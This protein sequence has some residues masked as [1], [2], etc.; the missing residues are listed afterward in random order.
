RL[1]LL[2]SGDRPGD[3]ARYRELRIDAHLLK[4]VQPEELIETIY[5]VMSLNGGEVSPAR[6]TVSPAMPAVAP[7]RI[8][9]AEDNEFNAQYLERLLSMWGHHV[10]LANDG[11]E[12]LTLA[13][14]TV[15]DLLLLDI[16]MPELD[17]FQVVRA[18][19]EREQ[20]AGGHLPVIALT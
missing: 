8:L 7:L 5:R 17:G 19:R 13:E 2:T 6:E 20:F 18:L 15:F 9:L 12:A 4:P 14:Q 3:L 11:R 1:I 10:Q 16:H